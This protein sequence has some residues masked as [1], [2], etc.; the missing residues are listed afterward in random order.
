MRKVIG[1]RGGYAA[2]IES[3]VLCDVVDVLIVKCVKV[4]RR[5]DSFGSCLVR[6]SSL[7]CLVCF[8]EKRG[9]KFRNG[10]NLP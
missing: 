4:G 3:T 10:A 2:S 5:D 9:E 6:I 1:H 7:N 8:G